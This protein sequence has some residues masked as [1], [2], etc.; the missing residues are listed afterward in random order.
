MGGENRASD[1]E[2]SFS[3]LLQL[4]LEKDL[5][6]KVLK[7]R[8]QSSG[9]QHGKDIH[10]VWEAGGRRYSWS[11]E[12][13]SHRS[14]PVRKEEVMPKILDTWRSSHQVD[15]WCLTLSDREPGQ[16]IDEFLPWARE[17][18][19]LPFGVTVLSP[20]EHGLPRLFACHEHFY[21]RLYPGRPRLNLNPASRRA[22]ID[23]FG[24]FLLDESQLAAE[25]EEKQWTLVLPGFPDRMGVLDEDELAAR[26]Y[27]RG[28]APGDWDAIAHGWAIERPSAEGP[29]LERFRR[30]E[31]GVT[32]SWLVG[33]SG[34]GKSTLARLVAWRLAAADPERCVLWGEGDLAPLHLPLDWVDNLPRETP[35]VLFVDGTRQL[36]EV[37]ALQRRHRRY[38]AEGK[39]VVCVL[40][41]R[42]VNFRRSRAHRELSQARLRPESLTTPTLDEGE[43]ESLI[44]LL[45]ERGVLAENS[46]EEVRSRLRSGRSRTKDPNGDGRSWLLP[47]LMELTDPERR[48]FEEILADFLDQLSGDESAALQ[49]LLA[50]ALAHAAGVALRQQAAEVLASDHPGGFADAIAVIESETVRQLGGA[51]GSRLPQNRLLTYNVVVAD[52]LVRVA[53]GS[54]VLREHLSAICHRL[55]SI[56]GERNTEGR[57]PKDKFDFLNQTT[58]Y[59]YDDLEAHAQT[60]QWLDDWV[61]LDDP[62]SNFIALQR[63]GDCLQSWLQEELRE[64]GDTPLARDLAAKG[65]QA[66]TEGL[67]LAAEI[68][69]GDGEGYPP[70]L[71]SRN[72]AS[73]ESVFFRSWAVLEDV[74]GTHFEGKPAHLRA[75]FFSVLGLSAGRNAALSLGT[76]GLDLIH[77][78]RPA[79]AAVVASALAELGGNR[80]VVARQR[81]LLKEL[82]AQV[83]PSGIAKLPEVLSRLAEEF[84]DEISD[85]G[86]PYSREARAGHLARSLKRAKEFLPGGD[87]LDAAIATITAAADTDA[88][89]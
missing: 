32:F 73:D 88:T 44:A 30:D 60:A 48:G 29:L 25:P 41:D 75:A 76:L 31:P 37:A 68:L 21:E 51:E 36:H 77:L 56:V 79:D 61:Q 24:Q 20:S 14:R 12:C 58:H 85:E 13:K 26:R 38:E 1:F 46:S 28:F 49:V 89:S 62:P 43:I 87:S 2:Q 22:T 18:L 17:T 4:V 52:G 53:L 81:Q 66:F 5:G 64:S 55:I 63:L 3:E 50:T 69:G 59:L 83:A 70:E 72:L 74:I 15:V 71:L 23:A 78:E 35:V 40:V 19:N 86:W 7:N 82:G 47:M 80:H 65:R 45:L 27:L 10:L 57:L 42:G 67:E 39:A 16:A 33:P 84:L 34:E 9:V 11:F 8:V 6:W 54:P